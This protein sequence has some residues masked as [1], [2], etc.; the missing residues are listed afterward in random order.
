VLL[1]LA[2]AILFTV[3]IKG[4][5]LLAR[6]LVAFILDFVLFGLTTIGVA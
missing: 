6:R 4:I 2:V 1:A 3:P 5:R